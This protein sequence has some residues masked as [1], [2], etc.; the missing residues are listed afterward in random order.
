MNSLLPDAESWIKVAGAAVA[1]LMAVLVPLRSWIVEDRRYRA[2]TLEA[3][4]GA[5]R[6]VVS[7]LSAPSSMLADTLTVAALAEAVNRV[8]AA[9]ETLVETEQDRD[10]DRLTRALERFL[11]HHGQ[12]PPAP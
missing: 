1:V 5:S 8:A 7:G 2:Q 11:L 3:L 6:T 12:G 9:M 4:T 10:K